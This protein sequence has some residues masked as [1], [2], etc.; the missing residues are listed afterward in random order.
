MK[1]SEFEKKIW[2]VDQIRVVIRASKDT[3]VGD[4]TQINAL[5]EGKTLSEYE[6][7]RIIPRANGLEYEFVD[8]KGQIPRKS[9]KLKT[10]RASYSE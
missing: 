9:T 2:E 1:V 3:M 10:L 8:G 5:D 6:D 4:F 7:T